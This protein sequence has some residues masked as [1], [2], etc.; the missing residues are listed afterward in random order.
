MIFVHKCQG[1]QLE[2]IIELKYTKIVKYIINPLFDIAFP[3]PMKKT[4]SGMGG[5]LLSTGHQNYYA[6]P[7]D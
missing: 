1:I 3:P 2:K 7:W 4:R 5:G 6:G